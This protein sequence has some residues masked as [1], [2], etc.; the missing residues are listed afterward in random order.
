LLIELIKEKNDKH[1]LVRAK[2]Q[3]AD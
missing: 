2:D 1:I 3:R